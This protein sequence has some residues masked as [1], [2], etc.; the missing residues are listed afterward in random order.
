MARI[1]IPIDA[2]TSRLN[3]QDRFNTMRSGGLTARF[4]NLRPISEFF[5]MKRISKPANF[6]EVQSRWNYNLSYFSSNYS[7]IFVMLSIYALLTNW[8]LLFDIIFVVAGMF[9][10]GKLEGRDL[11]IGSFRATT[12]QLWTGLL[13]ISVPV[14]LYA[15]PFSTLL[16]LVGASGVV[17]LGHAAFMDKPIDEAFSGEA[18]AAQRGYWE[19]GQRVEELETDE[20]DS[21]IQGVGL[22]SRGK[23]FASD[24]LR[25]TGTDLG[26]RAGTLRRGYDYQSDEEDDS[27]EADSDE[28]S[29]GS[30]SEEELDIDWDQLSPM[31]REEALVQTALA[32]I[33]RAQEKGRSDVRLNQEEMAAFERYK[34]RKE[35]EARRQ[36]RKRRKEKDHRFSIPLAQFEA[37]SRR[38]SPTISA[39]DDLP[40]HPS[41]GTF[42]E[43]QNRDPMPPMGYFPP[44][45][46]TR[47]RQRSSTSASQRPPSRAFGDRGSSPFQYAYIGARQSSDSRPISSRGHPTSEDGRGQ[48]NMSPA[49]STS[50][51]SR[52]RAGLDPFQF[53]TEGPRAQASAARRNVSGSTD[54]KRTPAV[55]PTARMTRS[56]AP[57]PPQSSSEDSGEESTEEST[58]DGIGNG[59]QIAQPPPPPQPQPQPAQTR[60]G[61]KEAIVVEEAASR[62]PTRET[63]RGKKSSNSSPSKKKPAASRKKKK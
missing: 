6:G 50:S 59:A 34:K 32:R 58:S 35:K 31:E 63:S 17:I 26:D 49:S 2:L 21:D 36:E 18:G 16:W 56:K 48:P 15:S 3:L 7:V 39:D 9:L 45:N 20:E 5:D 8:V 54:G 23:R 29:E 40:R 60:R 62:E 37:P 61:R 57:P 13:V 4:A 11:E 27:S 43:V 1:Q 28:D 53:Q 42:A 30:S 25:F 41:P 55:P 38:W 46:A 10:I 14:G 51:M 44:P 33:R 24:P 47:T 19:D 52:T 12:S 22:I